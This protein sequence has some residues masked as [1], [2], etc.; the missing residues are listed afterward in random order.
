MNFPGS[1]SFLKIFTL[2][3]SADMSKFN[4]LDSQ[5]LMILIIK[6]WHVRT[7]GERKNL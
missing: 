7:E 4:D 3:L 2:A 1:K 5:N 6:F